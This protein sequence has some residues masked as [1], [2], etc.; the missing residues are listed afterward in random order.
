V[1]A[2]F[3]LGLC[4]YYQGKIAEAH[5][6]WQQALKL[7]PSFTKAKQALEQLN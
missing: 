6:R 3:Y 1:E 7:D 5:A 2:I 4:D